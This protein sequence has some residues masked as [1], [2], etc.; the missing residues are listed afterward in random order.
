M[1]YVQRNGGKVVGLASHPQENWPKEFLKDDAPE[2]LQFLKDQDAEV[3]E[4]LENA[5]SLPAK[6]AALE[7]RIAAL[8]GK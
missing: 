3:A 2:I 1:P 7:K 6:V 5:S 8:E 4:A